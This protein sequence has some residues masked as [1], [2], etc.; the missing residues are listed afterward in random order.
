MKHAS[1]RQWNNSLM[2]A[3]HKP[4]KAKQFSQKSLA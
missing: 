1:Y 2:L 3:N 4:A